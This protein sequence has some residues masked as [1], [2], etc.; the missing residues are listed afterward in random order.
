[1]VTWEPSPTPSKFCRR[2]RVSGRSSQI[3]V[4]VL[5]PDA[6]AV[7]HHLF[8]VKWTEP[9]TCDRWD[10]NCTFTRQR[11]CCCAANDMYQLEETT[12]TRLKTLWSN[13]NKLGSNVL[14]HSGEG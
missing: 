10:C 14:E 7:S 11:G 2:L 1:M 3:L 5:P 4:H 9:L 13:V 6:A 8:P 12:F